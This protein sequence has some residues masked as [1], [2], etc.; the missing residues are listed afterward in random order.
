MGEPVEERRGHL[1]VAEDGG[2]FGEGQVG[3]DQDRGALVER[4][5]QMEEQLAAGLRENYIVKQPNNW[6]SKGDQYYHTTC[7]PQNPSSTFSLKMDWRGV[8][9]S[10]VTSAG[11]ITLLIVAAI[12]ISFVARWVITGNLRDGK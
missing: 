2:P 7:A 3:G 4:A 8:K 5:D 1:G 11:Q 9:D 10:E 12:L 6:T